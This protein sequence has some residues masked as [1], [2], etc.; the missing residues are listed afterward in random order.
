MSHSEPHEVEFESGLEVEVEVADS[1]TEDANTQLVAQSEL[2]E[3]ETEAELEDADSP[4]DTDN[5]Q[6]MAERQLN[7]LI[8]TRKGKLGYCTRKQNELK[9]FMD[10]GNVT[11]IE[12]GIQDLNDAMN[13]FDK[14]HLLVQDVTYPKV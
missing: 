2:P 5:V 10:S 1:P 12:K 3:V 14:A 13:E 4:T 6:I 9:T 11:D 7:Q 8:S